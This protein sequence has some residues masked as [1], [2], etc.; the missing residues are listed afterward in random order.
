MKTLQL[1]IINNNNDLNKINQNYIKI[2]Y[3]LFK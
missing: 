2:N 1:N 3:N